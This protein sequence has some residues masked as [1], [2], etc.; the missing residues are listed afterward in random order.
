M[1]L[2][3]TGKTNRND[4][5]DALSVAIA[6]LR[7]TAGTLV[8]PDD[9]AMVLKVWSKR[10]R[11]LSRARNQVVCRL[12]AVLC[13][14]IRGG[15]VK[16]IRAAAAAR[17]LEQARPSGAVQQAHHQLAGEFLADLRRID[18]QLRE[19]RKKLATAVRASGTRVLLLHPWW[20]L[21]AGVRAAAVGTVVLRQRGPLLSHCGRVG[22][23]TLGHFYI[24]IHDKPSQQCYR[25]CGQIVGSI[26]HE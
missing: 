3:A 10:Y 13:D 8:R 15:A 14:L 23:L 5:S 22:G 2:L 11:D 7:S 26:R 1:R 24:S 16:A 9:H 17:V 19:I 4:P 6:A 18:A 25:E 12:H 20:R 21:G